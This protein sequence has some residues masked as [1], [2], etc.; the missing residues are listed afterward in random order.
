ML[1]QLE[2]KIIKQVKRKNWNSFNFL[3]CTDTKNIIKYCIVNL[4]MFGLGKDRVASL[5]IWSF[6][7]EKK[8]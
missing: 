8:Y 3:K 1:E 2:I 4:Y 7:R 6:L 5:L